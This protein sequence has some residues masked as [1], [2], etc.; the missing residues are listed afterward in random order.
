MPLVRLFIKFRI[1]AYIATVEG[2][3]G[4]NQVCVS[5]LLPFSN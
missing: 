3:V 4:T 2:K 5:I 1:A